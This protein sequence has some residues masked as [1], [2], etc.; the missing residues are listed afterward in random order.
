MV[1]RKSSG[2]LRPWRRL[3]ASRTASL[4]DSGWRARCSTGQLVAGGVHDVDVL[5]QRLAHRAGQRLGA[6]VL[7]QAAPDLGLH[8]PAELL[9]AGLVLVGGQ[10]LLEVGQPVARRPG[11]GLA[12][13]LGQ[14]GVEVEVPQR[15]VEVVGAADRA[16]RLHAGVAVDRVAG[17]HVHQAVVGRQEGLEQQLGQLFGRHALAAARALATGPSARPV[18]RAGAR[19]RSRSARRPRA[20]SSPSTPGSAPGCARRRT[21]RRPSRRRASARR[22]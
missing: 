18:A 22:T 10:P 2:P 8:G 20:S 12:H 5:G 11:L 17:H 14:H 1:A 15:P 9:D 16:A 19:R 21:P 3:R 4:R 7:D 13:Q 6:A